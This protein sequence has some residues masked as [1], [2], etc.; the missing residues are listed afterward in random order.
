MQVCAILYKG[1]ER[2][3]ISVSSEV[4]EPIPHRYQGV[5]VERYFEIG[6]NLGLRWNC[7]KC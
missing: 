2:L 1:L 4:L 3:R 7:V 6:Y 5:T